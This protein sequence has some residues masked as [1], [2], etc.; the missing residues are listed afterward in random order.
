MQNQMIFNRDRKT[1][2][3]NHDSHSEFWKDQNHRI[4]GMVSIEYIVD[5]TN[6]SGRNLDN[7]PIERTYRTEQIVMNAEDAMCL[8][9]ALQKIHL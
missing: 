7:T 9:I 8:L 2:K 4:T 3:I 1:I 6:Y 5:T